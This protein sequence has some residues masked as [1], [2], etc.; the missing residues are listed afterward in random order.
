MLSYCNI[1]GVV[2]CGA[3]CYILLA[4]CCKTAR[5][6]RCENTKYREEYKNVVLRD[7]WS[8]I[9]RSW[10]IEEQQNSRWSLLQTRLYLA[11][12]YSSAH[13]HCAVSFIKTLYES[14]NWREEGCEKKDKQLFTVSCQLPVARFYVARRGKMQWKFEWLL[15][16]CRY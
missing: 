3:T 14:P 13:L 8:V 9:E 7:Q 1:R 16:A 6:W 5:T 12:K 11:L 10:E 4:I 15:V 2:A